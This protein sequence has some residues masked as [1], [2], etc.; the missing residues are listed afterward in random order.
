MRIIKANLLL[1]LRVLTCALAFFITLFV[2]F[3]VLANN[4]SA[5]PLKLLLTSIFVYIFFFILSGVV[6]KIIDRMHD[7]T[8]LRPHSAL[9]SDENKSSGNI[10]DM[11]Q[12]AEMPFEP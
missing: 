11:L 3:I 12:N 8:T 4:P 10:V 5:D 2:G 9:K 7:E 6:V 1:S